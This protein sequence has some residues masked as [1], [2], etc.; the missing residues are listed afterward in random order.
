MTWVWTRPSARCA[1]GL[2]GSIPCAQ[3]V[4]PVAA[5][6]ASQLN[7][8]PSLHPPLSLKPCPALVRVIRP[9]QR[10]LECGISLNSLEPQPAVVEKEL[11]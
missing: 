6:Y 3:P 5:R 9:L 4:G 8:L 10:A 2:P 1:V 11:L 7:D